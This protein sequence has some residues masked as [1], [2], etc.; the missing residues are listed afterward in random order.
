ME[1]TVGLVDRTRVKELADA[2]KKETENHVAIITKEASDKALVVIVNLARDHD[3]VNTLLAKFSVEKLEIPEG[4][5]TPEGAHEGVLKE[6]RR[7][8]EGT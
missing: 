4:E 7:K 1:V 2:L 6:A 5:G 8:R 3:K